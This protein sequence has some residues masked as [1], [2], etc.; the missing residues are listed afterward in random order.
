MSFQ[1]SWKASGQKLNIN[2]E[3]YRTAVGDIYPDLFTTN[4]F[5]PTT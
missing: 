2:A 4:S 5:F 1:N 3:L